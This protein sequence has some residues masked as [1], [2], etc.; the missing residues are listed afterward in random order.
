VEERVVL[1]G[2]LARALETEEYEEAARIRDAIRELD[3]LS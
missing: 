1:H 2:R 3:G